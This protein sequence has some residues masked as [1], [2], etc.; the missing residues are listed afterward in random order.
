M[1]VWRQAG[2]IQRRGRAVRG[3]VA[4]GIVGALGMTAIAGRSPGA[5]A[6]VEAEPR[7]NI[8]M[9]LADDLGWS[10]TSLYGTTTLHRTPNLQRLAARGV[11]FTRA[12]AASPL[13]SP[14]RASIL[15]G[16]TPARHGSTSPVHHLPEVRLTPQAKPH[17]PPGDRTCGVQSV[18]RLDPALPT[19]GRLLRAA[20]YRT[21]HVGKWHLGAEP[22]SPLEHGFEV[23]VPHT[24]G[25][26]PG[27]NFVAPL[28]FGRFAPR[29]ADEHVEDRMAAEAVALME[30]VK[31]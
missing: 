30:S 18:S 14:T 1:R 16:Q 21:A 26:G 31:D 12:Y 11:T 10:D 25:P 2:D 5:E 7:P 4:V 29:S 15:T 27:G 8:V 6:V 22:Y 19:L 20:G 23:D 9:I 28:S 13:C 3:L 24:S 17:G